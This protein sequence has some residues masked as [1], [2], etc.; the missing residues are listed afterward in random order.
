MNIK[1]QASNHKYREPCF[2]YIECSKKF[3]DVTLYSKKIKF[4]YRIQGLKKLIKSKI[5]GNITDVVSEHLFTSLT[6][7]NIV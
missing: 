4:Y 2:F 6:I 1:R 5:Q 7:M 3:K